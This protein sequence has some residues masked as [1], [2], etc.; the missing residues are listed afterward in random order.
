MFGERSFILHVR[1]RIPIEEMFHL[2]NKFKKNYVNSLLVISF[3]NELQ[4]IR[5]HSSIVFVSR[6][7]N[8]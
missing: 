4:L 5:L 1:L 6:Q 3:L 2:K 8:G 7:L